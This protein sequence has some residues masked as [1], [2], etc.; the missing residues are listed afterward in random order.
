MSLMRERLLLLMRRNWFAVAL[1]TLLGALVGG[2]L[3]ML[4]PVSYEASARLFVAAPN[5]NDSTVNPDPDVTEHSYGDTFTQQRMRSYEALIESPRVASGVIERLSLKADAS[6]VAGRIG[7]RLVPDTVM[8]DVRARDSNNQQAAKIAN[9]AAEELSG[10]IKELETPTSRRM[11]PVQPVLIQPAAIPTGPSSPRVL[12][13][14]LSGALGGLLLG[15]TYVVVRDRA[16]SD[17]AALR[18]VTSGE[19]FLGVLPKGID[20]VIQL[21]VPDRIAEDVRF[22]RLRI[23]ALLDDA[24]TRTVLFVPPRTSDSARHA[25][26]TIASAFVEAGASIAVVVAELESDTHGAS[27]PGLGEVLDGLATLGSVIDYPESGGF[28]LVAG[29]VTKRAPLTALSSDEVDVVIRKLEERFEYVI[30]VGRPVL[31]SADSFELARKVRA[32]VLICE[33][34]PTKEVEVRESERLLSLVLP[35]TPKT[36]L[37]A[38]RSRKHFSGSAKGTAHHRSMVEPGARAGE[39]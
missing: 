23:A 29:G 19:D 11:S 33:V 8:I 12:L 18:R 2:A 35:D 37:V 21:D 26:L 1:F 32:A 20:P 39:T 36:I 5:W 14:L 3:N 38:E 16:D 17:R 10:L 6:D 15:I 22:V 30:I 28:G 25:G 31:E 9:A 34:P 24:D 7:A 27:C 13:N 4:V